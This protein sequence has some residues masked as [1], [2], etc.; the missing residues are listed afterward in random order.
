M[1]DKF[2]QRSKSYFHNTIS[3]EEKPLNCDVSITTPKAPSLHSLLLCHYKTYHTCCSVT[4]AMHS[5]S[6]MSYMLHEALCWRS[7]LSLVPRPHPAHTRRRGLVS[8]VQILGLAPEVWSGQSNRRA[9]FIGIMRQVLQS[10]RSKYCYEI[11]L[12]TN[13]YKT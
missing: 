2:Q 7:L 9:A 3:F 13:N 6:N 10:Y 8:Q 4:L 11:Q 12:Y 1:Q 5:T